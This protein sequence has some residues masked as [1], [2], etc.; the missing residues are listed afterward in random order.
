M[1]TDE[2]DGALHSAPVHGEGRHRVVDDEQVFVP[3]L[4][5][6][7]DFE[8]VEARRVRI[9]FAAA[10]QAPVLRPAHV[11]LQPGDEEVVQ[12]PELVTQPQK[13][14]VLEPGLQETELLDFLL[15]VAQVGEALAQGLRRWIVAADRPRVEA[16]RVGAIPQ[17]WLGIAEVGQGI[18]GRA[19]DVLDGERAQEGPGRLEEV[20]AALRACEGRVAK[21]VVG[22][23][24]ASGA[25]QALEPLPKGRW[26]VSRFFGRR[27]VPEPRQERV[28][29]VEAS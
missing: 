26:V 4:R 23:R 6:Q 29:W 17:G 8:P 11:S 27:L 20:E 2:A 18:E 28:F 3:P 15:G 5:A 21:D 10:Q 14:T 24:D 7:R 22:Q 12:G 13:D 9:V 25:R 1:T 19:A 16:Q